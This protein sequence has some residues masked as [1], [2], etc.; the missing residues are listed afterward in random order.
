M[1]VVDG[2]IQTV[3]LVNTLLHHKDVDL[4]PSFLDKSVDHLQATT[5]PIDP[6]DVMG[7]VGQVN[8]MV[9]KL[10]EGKIK[11]LINQGRN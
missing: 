8:G 5:T 7:V 10:T 2:M 11:N 3:R 6:T 9:E 4:S 1:E